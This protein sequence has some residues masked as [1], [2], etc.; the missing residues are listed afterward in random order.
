MGPY[1]GY[2]WSYDT[3][4]NGLIINLGDAFKYSLLSPLIPWGSDE[5]NLTVRIY[6]KGLVVQP[7]NQ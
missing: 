2:K 6:S 1:D 4:I 5:P 7:T 3:L